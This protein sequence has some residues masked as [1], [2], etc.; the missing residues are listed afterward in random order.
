MKQTEQVQTHKQNKNLMKLY[1]QTRSPPDPKLTGRNDP[2][3]KML[4]KGEWLWELELSLLAREL[5]Q[6]S[7]CGIPFIF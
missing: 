5:G 6:G 2:G 1:K 7:G 3:R 4:R